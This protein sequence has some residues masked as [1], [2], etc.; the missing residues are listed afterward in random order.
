MPDSIPVLFDTDIGSDIDD[1]LALSYLLA[2]RRAHLL[3]VST[4]S[5]GAV[6]RAR[7]A[8]AICRAAG[9]P[10]V[11]VWS[12]TENPVVGTQQQPDVPQAQVLERWDHHQDFEPNRAVFRMRE[13]IRN[14]PEEIALICVGPLTNVGLLFSLDPQIPS[15]LDRLVIMGGCYFDS[16]RE[17]N[18]LCDPHAATIVFG[19]EVRKCLVYGLDV[20]RECT[21]GAQECRERLVGG[22]LEL[23][24]E[25]AE[26][27]F[28]ERDTITFHD[29]LAACCAFEPEMCRYEYGF[30]EVECG[31]AG[32][33]GAT[34]FTVTD[35]GQHGV[36]DEV[37]VTAF[38]DRY[39]GTIEGFGK[40]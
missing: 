33:G 14:H 17:W 34:G 10:E 3:G 38:F 39:F 6:D 18:I 23:V 21:L 25:M 24:A 31:A 19:A 9:R 2:E 12:G 32:R 29:P 7:L 37:D 28:G 40:Q 8:D 22:P 26:V 27:W 16:T 5:G 36:A 15:L 35:G 13:V 20:T 30:V 11:P 1:A 4:V